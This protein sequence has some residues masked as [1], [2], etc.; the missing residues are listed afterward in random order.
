MTD[1]PETRP[2]PRFLH[3]WSVLAVCATFVLLLIGQYAVPAPQPS[4]MLVSRSF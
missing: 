4:V 1:T 2:A 3:A